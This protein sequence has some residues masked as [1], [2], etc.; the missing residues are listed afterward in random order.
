MLVTVGGGQGAHLEEAG[1]DIRDRRLP[2]FNMGADSSV[3]EGA[4]VAVVA[5]DS[6]IVWKSATY[7][8]SVNCGQTSAR[9]FQGS[10]VRGTI[11]VDVTESKKKLFGFPTTGAS[12]SIMSEDDF[13]QLLALFSLHSRHDCAR[14]L[15]AFFAISLVGA[16]FLVPSFLSLLVVLLDFFRMGGAPSA[17]SFAAGFFLFFSAKC[18]RCLIRHKN[19]VP[20]S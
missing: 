19:R 8:V 4:A 12:F 9:Y 17:R 20:L 1:L 6:E 5:F 7:Y 10:S 2:Q 18:V 16:I 15:F 13:F 3:S 14:A 11:L